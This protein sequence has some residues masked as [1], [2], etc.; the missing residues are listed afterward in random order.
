MGYDVSHP[1]GLP[2]D[3]RAPTVAST[4]GVSSLFLPFLTQRSLVLL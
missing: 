3:K 1:T 4:I 2:M